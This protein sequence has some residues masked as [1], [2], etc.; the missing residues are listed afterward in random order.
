M[1]DTDVFEKG[2]LVFA[3]STFNSLV[4]EAVRV[5]LDTQT[6]VGHGVALLALQAS[7]SGIG[8][9]VVDDAVVLNQRERGNTV[10]AP[11]G[12]VFVAARYVAF[13]SLL[14]ISERLDAGDTVAALV[15]TAD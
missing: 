3:L 2:E 4:G 15:D 9:A 13:L 12:V 7:V 8:Q 11:N 10:L 1:D 14:I 6:L 5:D